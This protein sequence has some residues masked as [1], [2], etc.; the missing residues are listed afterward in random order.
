MSAPDVHLS[1]RFPGVA[2]LDDLE[3]HRA[4]VIPRHLTDVGSGPVRLV[5]GEGVPV[6]EV[7]A[8]GQLLWLSPRSA[9]PFERW[10]SN[11]FDAPAPAALIDTR[12]SLT[13]LPPGTRTLLALASTDGE[14]NSEDLALVRAARDSA[15]QLGAE[16]VVIPLGRH[17]TE[18][19][20]KIQHIIS[21]LSRGR[22]LH[23]LTAAQPAPLQWSGGLVVLFT[24]LSGSGKSTVA[25]ALAHNLMED[26][27]RTVTL[28]DGDL[29]RRHLSEGLGFSLEDRDTNVRRIG[30]VAAEI[31]RHGGTAIASP[32]APR[33]VVRKEVRSMV[34]RRGGRF[35]LVHVA[36]PLAECELRDRKGLYARAR[37]GAIPDFTGI[38]SPYDVPEDAELRVDTSGRGV[39]DVRDEVLHALRARGWLT[40]SQPRLHR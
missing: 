34:T 15:E 8:Q 13:S 6:A 29:V 36:T 10:H 31:A 26:A 39:D 32:I 2:T 40:T 5:D 19:Q 33:D 22:G 37:A 12:E 17:T 9:R 25:R 23:D 4:G 1:E 11:P 24:G 7:D 27:G 3:L 28:L 21:V 18:R 16:L 35:L 20:H 38:S 14:D 30:W